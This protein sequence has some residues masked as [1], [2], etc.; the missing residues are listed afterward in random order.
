MKKE[1]LRTDMSAVNCLREM[2]ESSLLSK[3]EEHTYCEE[4]D[5]SDDD[6][7]DD[8]RSKLS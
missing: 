1:D 6:T 8:E 5:Y 7:D 4:C 3:E 2:N